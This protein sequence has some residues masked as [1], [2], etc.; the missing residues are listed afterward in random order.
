MIK[1]AVRIFCDY[2][3]TR[4]PRSVSGDTERQALDFA[5]MNN[6]YISGRNHLCPFHKPR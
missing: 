1:R 4:C 6:W 5:R 3:D 2:T